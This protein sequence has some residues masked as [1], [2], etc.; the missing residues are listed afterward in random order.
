MNLDQ[1][2]GVSIFRRLVCLSL[3]QN[4]QNQRS[5]HCWYFLEKENCG[6]IKMLEQNVTFRRL[7][8]S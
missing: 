6:W 4:G 7:R 1:A 3:A 8:I 2:F 5:E